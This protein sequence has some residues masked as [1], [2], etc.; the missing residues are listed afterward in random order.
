MK[1]IKFMSFNMR[2]QVE[3]DGVNQFRSRKERILDMLTREDPDVIGF[4]ELDFFTKLAN[5]LA[6]DY[7]MINT[8]VAKTQCWNCI[9]YNKNTLTLI[10]Q[11]VRKN[12]KTIF[13]YINTLTKLTTTTCK[14]YSVE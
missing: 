11:L 6:P 1:K 12:T 10:Q 3:V 4:Q 5:A 13:S 14:P 9:A 2:T 7:A 8:A